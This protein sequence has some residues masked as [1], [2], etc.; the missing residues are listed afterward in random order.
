MSAALKTVSVICASKLLTS[1]KNELKQYLTLRNAH[2]L[3]SVKLSI[4]HRFK[5][6]L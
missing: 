5:Y 1:H 3:L 4:L 6:K 2:W